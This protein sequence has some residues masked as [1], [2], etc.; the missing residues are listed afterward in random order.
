MQ[1]AAKKTLIKLLHLNLSDRGRDGGATYNIALPFPL[2]PGKPTRAENRSKRKGK[3]DTKKFLLLLLFLLVV[4][5]AS[6]SIVEKVDSKRRDK[7]DLIK[8]GEK[9]EDYKLYK[10]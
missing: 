3:K 9:Q 8:G 2:Q 6:L 5:V 4:P 10:R 7:G 1:T